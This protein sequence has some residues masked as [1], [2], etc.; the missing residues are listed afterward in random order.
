MLAGKIVL[1]G[2]TVLAGGVWSTFERSRVEIGAGQTTARKDRQE[3]TPVTFC[4]YRLF[5]LSFANTGR[6]R[7]SHELARR[8]RSIS[9]AP[10]IVCTGTL[11]ALRG[12]TLCRFSQ[13]DQI[14][15]GRFMR[16]V[17]SPR[18]LCGKPT[19][20]SHMEMIH[21]TAPIARTNSA[22]PAYKLTLDPTRV[23]TLPTHRDDTLLGRSSFLEQQ[24]QR[25]ATESRSCRNR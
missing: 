11:T 20:K 5:H 7:P 15:I 10:M 4:C 13:R 16:S 18:P 19:P 9:C 12:D 23:D 24:H 8:D 14:P 22:I 6:D 3:A 21:R 2:E 25:S 17:E 1:A